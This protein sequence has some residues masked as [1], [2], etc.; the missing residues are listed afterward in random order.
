MGQPASLSA[1]AQDF[2]KIAQIARR[3]AGPDQTGAVLGWVRSG[4]GGSDQAIMVTQGSLVTTAVT[5]D[6]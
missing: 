5:R 4:V 6:S 1:S 2:V 3:E